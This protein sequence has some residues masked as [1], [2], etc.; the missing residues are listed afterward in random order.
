VEFD[1][2]IN[3]NRERAESPTVSED[4]SKCFTRHR[5]FPTKSVVSPLPRNTYNVRRKERRGIRKGI[6]HLR[7][8]TLTRKLFSYPT[9]KPIVFLVST[10][11]SIE[12]GTWG[13]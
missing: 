8:F 13:G 6:K 11:Q 3:E 4:I 5:N 12:W 1:V 7:F 10:S 9:S 2:F